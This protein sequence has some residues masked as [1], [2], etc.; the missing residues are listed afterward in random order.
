[1]GRRP[2]VRVGL[3]LP[4]E[5]DAATLDALAGAR[6]GL[7]EAARTYDLLGRVLETAEW[8][9]ANPPPALFDADAVIGLMTPDAWTRSPSDVLVVDARAYTGPCLPAET[10]RPGTMRIGVDD[11]TRAA[12]V[13]LPAAAGREV[14]RTTATT[15]AS[16]VVLWHAALGRYGATQLNERF[17]RRFDRPMNQHAWAAWMASRVVAESALRAAP[18]ALRQHLTAPRTHFDGHKGVPLSFDDGGRLLQPL[19][20]VRP[21]GRVIEFPPAEIADACLS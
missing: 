11:P 4:D 21:D 13:A 9:P 18:G 2:P 6:L 12:V 16:D 15:V 20:V 19:Y 5:M 1:M 14:A 10:R 3:L 7:E 17:A 8:T